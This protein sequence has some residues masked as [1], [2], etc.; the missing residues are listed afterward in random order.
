[1]F[2]LKWLWQNLEGNRT[3]YILALCLSVV[4]SSLTIV[5][6]YISQRIVDT[7]IAGD[8]ALQNLTQER[9]LLIMLC[10]G[11]IGFSLLRTGLAYFTTMQYEISSQNMMYNVRI[12]LYNKIQGQDR[13]Y[14][15][16]NRT[17]DLMTKMTGDLDMVRHSMAWIFKTIIESLTIFLAAVIYFFTIDAE[18]TLWMLILSP[19]IFIVAYIFAKRVRPM[20][21]DLRER[22][23][24]LNTTTQENISGNRVVK[25]FAR[26]E[27]E[28][29]KFTEKNVNYSTANKKAA[30]V[31]LDYFPYLESFAQGFN[32]ILM[33]VG[34][35]FLMNGRITFGEFMAF[36]SLIWAISN[37]MRNIGIIIN[38]IQRFFAS[39]SKIVDIYYARPNIVNEHTVTDKRRYEGRIEFDHVRF[40]YDSAIVLDDISF[41]VEPGET[42][43]IMGATGSGKTTIIN[44][45]PRFYDV[46]EGRVLVDGVDVRQLEL[47]ELRG[48]IGMATQ[49]V[50]LF[51]DTIDGNIA[52]GD[53]DLP[54]EDAMGYAELAAAHDF[55]T[56]MPEGYDT[57]VGERGVGLSGGQK[58][59]IALA[60][61]LAVHRPIL[62][63]DDTTSA[64]DLETEEHIQK[65]LRELDY[66][67]TKIIIAQR[68]STTSQADRIL[69]LD[70]GKLVEEGTHTELLA[71][72]G[73]YYEVFKLQNEGIGR[74]VTASGKE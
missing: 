27:F 30:L 51:S 50:L 12:Y 62:I 25:A 32:V 41:T 19:P 15:D 7:F 38:D 17:G 29:E 55:I 49:D 61:A 59:R 2:E 16:H 40:K 65:S 28:V 63:L 10:L 21:I 46:A 66:P 14:Y 67:C 26:E 43:A 8:N 1:M 57:V 73:Y 9:Q 31:W 22:L 58:Q 64:V 6:P 68:V 3:R 56:K 52:Y 74:Q 47:D 11:M 45:I 4:G 20:Y 48:N 5:N 33:L 13:K 44:L 54:E 24:Q 37:P 35:L 18:L 34:G 53:P 60:R 71:K 23:S 39:L 70:G 42:V 69:I 72:R 36:S